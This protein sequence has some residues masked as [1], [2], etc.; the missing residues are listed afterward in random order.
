MSKNIFFISISILVFSCSG[1][2]KNIAN[3]EVMQLETENTISSSSGKKTLNINVSIPFGKRITDNNIIA[4][5]GHIKIKGSFGDISSKIDANT[6]ASSPSGV[7]KKVNAYGYLNTKVYGEK[8]SMPEGLLKLLIFG[9]APYFIYETDGFTGNGYGQKVMNSNEGPKITGTGIT[10]VGGVIIIRYIHAD[11][12]SVIPNAYE[13]KSDQNG[14]FRVDKFSK[15]FK[16]S[17]TQLDKDTSFSDIDFVDDSV[18]DN[19]PYWEGNLK[20]I[21]EEN[22]FTLK[23]T[24]FLV[25]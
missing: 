3:K 5:D 17:L 7:V 12:L 6:G 22:I 14:M 9:A 13:I 25:E 24:L 15:K 16:R 20:G 8:A 2:E 4:E 11:A 18:E 21:F 1:S 19:V 23:G 10:K